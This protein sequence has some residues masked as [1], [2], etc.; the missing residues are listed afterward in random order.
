M[1]PNQLTIKTQETI[2]RAQNLVMAANQQSIEVA[3]LLLAI[4]KE[5]T[6]LLKFISGKLGINLVHLEQAITKEI[7]RY[8]KVEGAKVYA[9]QELSS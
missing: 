5:D 8:T 1:N 2:N 6:E 9:S 4:I 7:E 3:H